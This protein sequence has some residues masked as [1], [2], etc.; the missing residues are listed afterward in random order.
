MRQFSSR[1]KWFRRAEFLSARDLIQH[2]LAVSVIFLIVHLCGLREFTSV[3][4]G[5]MGSTQVSRG[6]AAFLGII[7]VVVYVGFVVLVP[8]L[9]LA[10]GLLKIGERTSLLAKR[11]Q[12]RTEERSQYPMNG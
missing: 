12:D 7:Y 8:I 5:T 9:I 2:A 1:P 11:R 6:V 4:N 3:L 10:A